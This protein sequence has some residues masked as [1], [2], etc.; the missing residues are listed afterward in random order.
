M[1]TFAANNCADISSS[2][3]VQNELAVLELIHCFVEVLV[4]R[5]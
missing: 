4:G 1:C 2:L 3:T 5:Q